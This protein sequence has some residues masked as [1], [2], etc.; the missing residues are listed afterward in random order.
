M[1]VRRNTTVL[2]DDVDDEPFHVFPSD[3]DTAKTSEMLDSLRLDYSETS[4]SV[5]SLNTLRFL[6]AYTKKEN[7]PLKQFDIRTAFLYGTNNSGK[8]NGIEGANLLYREAVDSLLCLSNRS[9]PDI[10]YAVN[11]ASRKMENPTGMRNLGLRYSKNLNT[12]L[13]DAYSDADYAGD[14][15]SRRSTS[16][17]VTL[18]KESPVAW[19]TRKQPIISLSTGESEFIAAS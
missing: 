1:E 7:M 6:I 16:G 14:E 12:S 5:V 13:I 2:Q 9:R 10:T 4:S 3:Q 19:Y 15:T 18:F 8:C 17:Y 11:M